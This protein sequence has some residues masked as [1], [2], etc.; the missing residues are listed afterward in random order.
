MKAAAKTVSCVKEQLKITQELAR[1]QLER[2]QELARRQQ[3]A[4]RRQLGGILVANPQVTGA[5]CQARWELSA[6]EG[7]QYPVELFVDLG[8]L[9]WE[10]AELA[11]ACG[12]A[13]IVFCVNNCSDSRFY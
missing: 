10:E 2:T 8:I 6:M 11:G 7:I 12:G 5:T 1:K 13:A 3:E 4:A 9:R